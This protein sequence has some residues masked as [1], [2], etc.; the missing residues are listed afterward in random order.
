MSAQA[1]LPPLSLYAHFPWCVRKCPYCDFNS[2]ALRGELP[3]DAYIDALL[4]DLAEQ[5]PA[6]FRAGS[7][8]VCFS[9]AALRAC[10]PPGPWRACARATRALATPVTRC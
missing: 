10:S 7:C 1:R 9:V 4:G 8:R 6:S 5:A 2:H 3:E